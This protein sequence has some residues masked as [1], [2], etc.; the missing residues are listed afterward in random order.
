[1]LCINLQTYSQKRQ[2]VKQATMVGHLNKNKG[3]FDKTS[4][5]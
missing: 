5:E 1:M 2:S 4:Q 3:V